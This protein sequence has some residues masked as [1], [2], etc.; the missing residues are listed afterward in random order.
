MSMIRL[1]AACCSITWKSLATIDD[2][3]LQKR[4]LKDLVHDYVTLERR[5]RYTVEKHPSFQRG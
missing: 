2:D 4:L 5:G 1:P 3:A